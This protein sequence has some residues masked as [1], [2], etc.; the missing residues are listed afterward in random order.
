MRLH[1]TLTPIVFTLCLLFWP[2]LVQADFQAGKDAYDQG[3]YA[4]AL[5]EWQ[6]L[7]KQGDAFAQSN[8]G[9]LYQYGLG[10]PQD[11]QEAA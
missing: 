7:A 11:Y 9:R 4:T 5:K 8:L 10:V 2:A 1:R 3:D 6:P